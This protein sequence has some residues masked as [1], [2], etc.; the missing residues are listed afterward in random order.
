MARWV[1][2][3][4]VHLRSVLGAGHDE[5]DRVRRHLAHDHRGRFFVILAMLIGT[6]VFAYVVGSACT[7]VAS[8]DKKSS[9]HHE[10]MDTLNAMARELSLGEDL[11]RRCRDYSG[12]DTRA[13]TWTTGG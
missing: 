12:T 13:R 3:Q 6:S 7:I 8:M 4:H 11:Q 5:H 2:L 1:Y 9:E 10:L